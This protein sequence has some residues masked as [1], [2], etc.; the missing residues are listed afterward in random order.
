MT[1]IA[2]WNVNSLN[3]RLEHVMN[4]LREVKPDIVLLQET[5]VTD[6]KFPKEPLEDLGYNV[7][8]HGQKTYNGVAILSK[9][10]IEDLSVGLPGDAGDEQCRYIEAVVGTRR[11]ISVYVP[12]GQEPG[13]DKFAYKMAFY[14]RL[15]AHITTLLHYEEALIMGGDYNV[16]LAPLDTHDPKKCANRILFTDE[17][18][19]KLRALLGLGLYDAFRA[20]YPEKKE[21][22]WWDYREGSWQANKGMRIDYLLLSPQATDQLEDAGID[23]A[24]RALQKASDHTP[25]WCTL[26]D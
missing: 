6:D 15:N 26:K 24:P 16:A 4:W 19:G 3:A 17:E 5:K 13:S 7:A 8:C 11:V 1:R 23:L 25:V 22:S 2:S 9:R 18:R 10:P 21:F 12:N 14:D 20:K